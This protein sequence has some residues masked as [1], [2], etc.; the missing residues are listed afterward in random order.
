MKKS[1]FSVLVIF[2]IS[3]SEKSNKDLS[4]IEVDLDRSE[5]GKLSDFAESI[6]YI[7]LDYP[8]EFPMVWPHNVK[9]DKYNNIYIRDLETN[10][11]FVFDSEGK[12][13]NI[14]LPKGKGPGEFFQISDFQITD[15]N[16]IIFDTSINKII[17][18][19][20]LGN[21]IEELRIVNKNL[22]FFQGESYIL[23]FTSYNPEYKG[24]NFIKIED[25]KDG[26]S[27]FLPISLGKESIGNFD[28]QVG[29]MEDFHRDK[30]YFNVPMSYE[31]VSFDK[32]AGNLTRTQILNF[33]KYNMP[34]E[35]LKLPRPEIYSLIEEKNL[36]RDISSFFPFNGFYFYTIRQGMGKKSHVLILDESDEIIYHK[37]NHLNDIDGM[38][39]LGFPWSFTKNEVV[40]LVSSGDFYFEY[41]KSFNGKKVKGSAN[42][43]HGFF[44]A[45]ESKLKDD[46]RILVKYKLK[47]FS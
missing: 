38:G 40:H 33:N 32:K 1:L 47:D 2:F 34:I 36:V 20:S 18:F 39:I 26:F 25:G 28:S 13:K 11:L 16:A 17:E 23:N 14:F 43:I 5:E 6:E 15:G 19:D 29:F 27:G 7:L 3:C 35:Y 22:N 12:F 10:Q 46:Y 31:I 45:N 42:N 30:V 24:F 37:Y 9:F 4:E 8:E 41:L 44:K 21:F